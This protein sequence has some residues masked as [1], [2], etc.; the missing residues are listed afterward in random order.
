MKRCAGAWQRA[1]AVV[2]MLAGAPIV[3]RAGLAL[4]APETV[5]GVYERNRQQ[6]RPNYIT[7]D[8]LLLAY[9]LIRERAWEE[10]E[11]AELL[12]RVGELFASL[13]QAA[14]DEPDDEPGR[15][16]RELAG[17]LVALVTDAAEPPAGE[18]ARAEWRFVRGAAGVASSPLFGARIDYSQFRPRGRYTATPALAA[19]FRAVR[20]AQTALFGVQPSAATGLDAATAERLAVQAARLAARL[21]G[22]GPLADLYRRIETVLGEQ[23]G[24]ADDLVVADV[25]A[26]TSADAGDGRPLAARL[27]GHAASHDRLPRILGGVVDHHRLEPALTPAHALVGWRLLAARYTPESAAM[28]GLVWDRVGRHL[29]TGD[30]PAPFTLS[31]A[32]GQPVKG[33]PNVLELPAL[34]GSAGARAALTRAGDDRYAGYADAWRRVSGHLDADA[35]ADGPASARLAFLRAGFDDAATGPAPERLVAMLG[36]WTYQ[37]RLDQLYVKQGYTLAGKSLDLTP[38]AARS[39]ATLEFE[40]LPL[41]RSLARYVDHEQVV[42]T[43]PARLAFREL[44]A[45]CIG[46]A[47]RVQAGAAP[48]AGDEDFLNRLDQVLLGLAGGGDAPIVVDL[49]TDAASGEVLELA[50]GPARTVR[51]GE[52]TGARLSVY[53]FRQPLAERLSDD[54]WRE[55]LRTGDTPSPLDTGTGAGA[56]TGA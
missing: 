56:G 3:A 9:A 12:P 16:N 13:Q 54:A 42:A 14:D 2:L 26:V 19:Y 30:C 38:P 44:L 45:H 37:R 10:T 28:Q 23:F 34:L 8:L 1:V 17:L 33:M 46:I 27:A 50:T 43:H 5:F 51:H 55:R 24:P 20:Y 48:D 47:E 40:A 32:D 21:G 29:C 25:L 31:L 11:R 22:D 39:G 4:P 53:Q 35:A 36:F 18:R 52:A 15:A 6:G 41:L 49:H 7:Q